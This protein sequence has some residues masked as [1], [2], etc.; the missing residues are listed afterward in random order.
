MDGSNDVFQDNCL[1]PWFAE[2]M[3]SL[4]CFCNPAAMYHE[5]KYPIRLVY[6][7]LEA[8]LDCIT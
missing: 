8:L 3:Y 6:I 2:E 5:V 4:S 1:Q 7:D